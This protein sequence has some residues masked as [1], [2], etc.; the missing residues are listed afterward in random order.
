MNGSSAFAGPHRFATTH[1]S[2]V[3]AAA[4][5]D[6]PASREALQALC[7]AYWYPLYAFV[8]R[9]GHSADQAQDLTQGFF[10]RFLDKDYLKSVDRAKGKFRSFLL[11][12][13][14]HFLANEAD[15]RR[16]KKRGGGRPALPLDFADAEG[17]YAREPAHELTPERLFERRWA[18]TLLDQVLARLRAEHDAAGHGQL[19]E[20][21]KSCL[22]GAGRQTPY[23]QL[24]QELSM[25][26]A[27]VKVAAHRLR[28]RYR[29]LLR[30]EIG[31][32]LQRPDDV[33]DEIRELF[34]AL[35]G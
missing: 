29:D 24:G 23:R 15:R 9:S 27:A 1:W 21:L 12:S 16:A 3:L 17:R 8:R 18:L 7:A 34:S 26:E 2:L 22:T 33:E 20:K 28:R 5:R 31:R 6:E 35:A 32:T 30:E 25:S 11:A 4:K 10:T 14:R 19:F 13:V